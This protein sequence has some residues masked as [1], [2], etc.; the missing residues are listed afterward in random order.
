MLK[1]KA[2]IDFIRSWWMGKIVVGTDSYFN[3][4]IESVRICKQWLL[5]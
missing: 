4:A 3:N 2:L 1:C 5:K